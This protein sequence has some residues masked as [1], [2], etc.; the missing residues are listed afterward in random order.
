MD[1]PTHISQAHDILTPATALDLCDEQ[2]FIQSNY[3]LCQNDTCEIHIER[4]FM[5]NAY[6]KS[7]SARKVWRRFQLKYQDIT[8]TH[9]E[10]VYRI[11]N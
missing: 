9:R 11:V 6:V 8:V 3:F 1:Q 5:Y 2:L 7:D 4:A 10:T